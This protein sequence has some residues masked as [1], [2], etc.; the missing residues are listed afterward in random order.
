M[1]KGKVII[2]FDD[3]YKDHLAASEFMEGLGLRGVFSITVGWLGREDGLVE[4]DLKRIQQ[5]GHLV[6]NHSFNH[7]DPARTSRDKITTCLLY[8][9]DAADE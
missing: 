6:C 8:T 4:A 5:A 2:T 9:S 7:L 1:P 3:G